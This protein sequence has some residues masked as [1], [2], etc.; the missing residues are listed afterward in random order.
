MRILCVA[1]AYFPYLATGGLAVTVHGLAQ[2]LAR[3]GH[4]LTVLTPD[5]GPSDWERLSLAP[6][7]GPYGL[8]YTENGVKA[9]YLRTRIR[10]RALTVNP[11]A[12]RFL[13]DSLTDFDLAHVF[14]LYDFLGPVV[15]RFCARRA[16]PY[17]VEPM[18][19]YVP[20]DRNLLAKRAW[21]VVLGSSLCRNSSRMIAT[22]DM[23]KDQFVSGG[24]P[25]EKILLRYNGIDQAF[26]SGLPLR[27]TFRAK[28]SIP[29]DEP[30]LL[31]LSRLIPRKG[32]DILIQAF[33]KACPSRGRLV[34]AGPEGHGGYEEA[35][36]RCAQE[37]G[38]SS[39]L[40]F[41]GPIFD[42]ERLSA[43]VDSDL[44]VLPSRYENF[45]NV[46][47]EAIAC[48]VPVVVS[49]QCGIHTLVEGRAGLVTE[50][51][52]H[53]LSASLLTLLT[54]AALYSRMKGGCREVSAEL[55]WSNLAAQMEAHYEQ[56]LAEARNSS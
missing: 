31:F 46:V 6:D 3:R 45:G 53:A 54:D 18:G 25:R 21:H 37:H 29:V 38:V 19:M 12:L 44:F 51:N 39:R 48:D 41:T 27:G 4:S 28:H 49:R 23:E 50:A 33:A 56:V 26:T 34:I 43:F 47:A 36:K 24:I 35:L 40:I 42:S 32:V 16:I 13:R 1:Q 10:H 55:S 17:F 20:M 8:C 30:L 7:H 11:S 15:G 2:E 9:I 52:P 14:G 22:C 5:L